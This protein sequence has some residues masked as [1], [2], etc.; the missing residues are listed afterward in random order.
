M[1]DHF[2]ESL[3]NK[4]E[5]T[6]DDPSSST[7]LGSPF[8]G[9]D[10]MDEDDV[11]KAMR[12]LP[13]AAINRV[14]DYEAQRDEPRERIAQYNIGYGESPVD[15]Q[16][17]RLSGDVQDADENKAV[18]ELSTREIPEDGPVVPGEGITGTG[19]PQTAYGS[20]KAKE[21]G[22]PAGDIKGTGRSAQRRGRRDRQPKPPEPGSAGSGSLDRENE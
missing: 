9:Y 6:S 12:H 8:A 4:L 21:E 2:A 3:K 14:K 15:R 7:R 20:K 13:S 5:V 1:R 16:E 11:L 19:D 18:R 17:G 10:D 22:E